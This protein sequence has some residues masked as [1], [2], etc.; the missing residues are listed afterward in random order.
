MRGL[1]GLGA[2]RLERCLLTE[3][4]F[5]SQT[6]VYVECAQYLFL[7]IDVRSDVDVNATGELRE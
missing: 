5:E 6:G 3:S 1:L 7:L 4:P 2:V